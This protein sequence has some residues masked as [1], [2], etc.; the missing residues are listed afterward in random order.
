MKQYHPLKVWRFSEH[1]TQQN[2]A[3]AIGTSVAR[4]CEIERGTKRPSVD[5]AMRV[6]KHTGLTLDEIF[7]TPEQAARSSPT[8]ASLPRRRS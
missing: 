7:S 5:L 3:D 8:P 2:V 4:I 6:A 1:V